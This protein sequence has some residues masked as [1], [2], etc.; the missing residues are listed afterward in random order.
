MPYWSETPYK[1]GANAIKFSARPITTQANVKPA[2]TGPDY[3][4][5]VMVKQIGSEDVYFEF[6]IQVQNDPVKMPVEDSVVDWDE[7]IAPF[8]R[9]ALI[10]IP[11]QDISD[12]VNLDIAEQLSFTP[13]HALPEHRPLGS[14]NRAR[15]VI[16]QTL[17]EFRH[18]MNGTARREPTEYGSYWRHEGGDDD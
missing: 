10:R 6:L 11:K 3:L 1:L 9:V 14:I 16:Y 13:W 12:P 5:E 4:C 2:V 7:E 15:R 17:S 8:Q 18:S